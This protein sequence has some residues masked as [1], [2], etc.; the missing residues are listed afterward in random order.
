MTPRA[1]RAALALL[2]LLAASAL[3]GAPARATTSDAAAAALAA[4]ERLVVVGVPVDGNCGCG[5]YDLG[6]FDLL[7][8]GGQPTGSMSVFG[9]PT[10]PPSVPDDQ[11]FGIFTFVATLSDGSIVGQGR[12]PLDNGPATVAIV[13]GTGRYRRTRGYAR[14]APRD[15]GSVRVVLHLL[16]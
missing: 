5:P 10:S 16:S 3:A 15:D 4:R 7:D 8:R 13:G 11:A 2:C 9:I 1:T 6:D 12:F 14:F